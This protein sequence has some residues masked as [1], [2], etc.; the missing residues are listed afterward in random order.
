MVLAVD[1]KGAD[2]GIAGGATGRVPFAEMEWAKPTLPDQKT[3]PAPKSAAEVVKPGDLIAVEAIPSAEDEAATPGAAA[4]GRC[5]TPM[6]CTA[7]TTSY[8][9]RDCRAS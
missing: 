7:P 3:G 4:P 8:R 1:G 6:W 9:R 5:A 2:I